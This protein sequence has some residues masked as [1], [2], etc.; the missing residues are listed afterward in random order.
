MV[1][2]E[3]TFRVKSNEKS[4]FIEYTKDNVRNSLREEGV[5]RFEFYQEMDKDN[6]FILFE[7]YKT[8]DDQ[9]KHRETDHYKRWK[10]GI[11]D[12]IE[13]PYSIR[14]YELLND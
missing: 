4:T 5:K 2:V 10:A 6:I 12:L 11:S 7:I 14:R 9:L 8:K 13:E 1:I 3:V